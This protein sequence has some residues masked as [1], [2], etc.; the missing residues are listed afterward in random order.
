M[1]RKKT[2]ATRPPFERI[3]FIDR[4]LRAE[5]YPT[6]ARLARLLNV[7]PRTAYRD[8]AYMREA[9]DAPV[10]FLVARRGY[11]YEGAAPKLGQLC[12]REGELFAIF[13][14]RKV[15]A[16]YRGTPYEAA[17]RS[18]FDKIRGALTDDVELYLDAWDEKLSFRAGGV[19]EVDPAIWATLQEALDCGWTVRMLYYAAYRDER[20]WRE[21]D[22]YFLFNVAGEWYLV[23]HCHLRGQ[24]RTFLPGRIEKLELTDRV[25]EPPANLTV[26]DFLRDSFQVEARAGCAPQTVRIRFAADQGPYLKGRRWHASQ[27]LEEQADGSLVLTLTVASEDELI[28][29]V[30]GWGANAEVLEPAALRQKATE[31]TADMARAYKP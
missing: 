1:A 7:T 18:A 4:E 16:Q 17:L 30:L 28:R 13:V 21:V 19:L 27:A 26:T 14:G 22:P 31:I 2:P 3:A 25:F 15:V 20:S 29:W 24:L 8:L 23:G 9:M 11:Y 12:L 10:K 5:R 6:L